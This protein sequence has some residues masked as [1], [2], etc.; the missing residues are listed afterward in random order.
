MDAC[1]T[2]RG[3]ERLRLLAVHEATFRRK[4]EIGEKSPWQ[5]GKG[6]SNIKSATRSMRCSRLRAAR[7]IQ[8][9]PLPEGRNRREPTS[10]T[11]TSWIVSQ[12]AR[13]ATHPYRRTPRAVW[14]D[15]KRHENCPFI[16]A[17]WRRLIGGSCNCVDTPFL[18]LSLR[19]GSRGAVIYRM[20]AKRR[21]SPLMAEGIMGTHLNHQ[22]SWNVSREIRNAGRKAGALRLTRQH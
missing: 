12:P 13:T 7:W 9:D 22:P 17:R 4:V 20:T 6:C 1:D 10:S 5:N 11:Y 16:Y 3:V 8:D 15:H 2:I 21:P 19:H 18:N 14:F